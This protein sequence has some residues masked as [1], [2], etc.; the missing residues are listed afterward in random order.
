MVDDEHHELCEK[1]DVSDIYCSS[2][3]PERLSFKA[4]PEVP[5]MNRPE[6]RVLV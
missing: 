2:L 4:M 3:A 5:G 1:K 6:S